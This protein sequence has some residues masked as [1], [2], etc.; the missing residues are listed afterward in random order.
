MVLQTVS[1][2]EPMFQVLPVQV[3][4]PITLTRISYVSATVGLPMSTGISLGA[5]ITNNQSMLASMQYSTR[6]STSVRFLHDLPRPT[7]LNASMIVL[8]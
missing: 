6:N 3:I 4:Q 5:S 2:V 7:A 8:G 1:V